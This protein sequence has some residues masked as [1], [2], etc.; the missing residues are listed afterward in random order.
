MKRR[1]GHYHKS[2]IPSASLG[3]LRRRARLSRRMVLVC[4]WGWYLILN[5]PPGRSPRLS[6]AG[7]QSCWPS[8]RR[9]AGQPSEHCS[10]GTG[11]GQRSDVYRD[12]SARVF[13]RVSA[14]RTI[15]L[16][17]GAILVWISSAVPKPPLSDKA[18]GIS[19]K[20]P[21]KFIMQRTVAG[22][23]ETAATVC[24]LGK[25]PSRDLWLII[26][27]KLTHSQSSGISELP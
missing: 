21:R 2:C 3:V 24:G 8:R 7:R 5:W 18:D 4:R 20:T 23:S 12:Q 19:D 13:S 10:R 26:S 9:R 11:S 17:N 27:S 16:I 1:Q 6:L 25:S 14:N 15:V 22:I